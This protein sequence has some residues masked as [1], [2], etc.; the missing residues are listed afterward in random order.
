MTTGSERIAMV[1][2]QPIG[3]VGLV[4]PWNFPL[5]D[6]SLENRSGFGCGVF[7]ST[8]ARTGNNSFDIKTCRN[9]P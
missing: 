8:K 9:C 7:D 4:L 3:V 2:R 5:F 6:G 1:V